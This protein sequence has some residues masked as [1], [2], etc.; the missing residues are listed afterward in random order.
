MSMSKETT[1]IHPFNAIIFGGDGDLS[2]RKIIPALF[3]RWDDGQL[4]MPFKVM[5]VSRSLTDTGAFHDELKSFILKT[6]ANIPA[7]RLNA[8]FNQV[9]LI[10]IPK[11][12]VASFQELKN[13]ILANPKW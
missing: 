5:C 1:K 7:E 12:D 9:E 11:N 4:N 8:F 10:T 2:K 13:S 3:H 6:S